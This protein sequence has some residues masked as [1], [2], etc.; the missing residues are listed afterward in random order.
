MYKHPS[1]LSSSHS[2]QHCTEY[3][4]SIFCIFLEFLHGFCLKN[5]LREKKKRLSFINH[6]EIQPL[7]D[8]KTKY[9]HKNVLLQLCQA[10][11]IHH[12]P[13]LIFLQFRKQDVSHIR[14]ISNCCFKELH[15]LTFIPVSIQKYMQTSLQSDLRNTINDMSQQCQLEQ[16]FVILSQCLY[17]VF[18]LSF[19]FG[20]LFTVDIFVF[21]TLQ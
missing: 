18:W 13:E 7:Y 21:N 9:V 15:P 3:L 11:S 16:Q 14:Y 4:Y 10:E 6:W 19:L 8:G 2:V 1:Y 17:H 20:L 5:W 12:P